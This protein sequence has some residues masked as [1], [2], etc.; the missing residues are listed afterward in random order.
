VGRPGPNGFDPDGTLIPADARSA[1]FQRVLQYQFHPDI[2]TD[3]DSLEVSLDK[4]F[5]QRWSGR[6]AYTLARSRDTGIGGFNAKRFTD[7]LNPSVDYGRS[8]FDNRHAFSM[9]VNA[10]PW[11]GLGLGMVLRAYSGYPINETVGS[12][13]NRDRDNND[14]PRAG[15]DDATLPILSPLGANGV[16][17]RN[18]ID[19]ENVF[20]MDLRLQYIF[21]LPRQNRVGLFWEVYNATNN[22][23]FANPTGNRNSANFMEPVSAGG[24][25]VMQLGIR[26][27]F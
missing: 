4:R 3:Y 12:D 26:Y 15:V 11:R 10:S 21:D 2:K 19:G 17:I 27:S 24:S 5:S 16:A 6:V 14:R 13:V 8:N 23:N 9:N 7:D 18:G 20:I 22:V 25:R 1:S